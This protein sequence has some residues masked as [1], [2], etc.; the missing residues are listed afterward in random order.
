MRFGPFRSLLFAAACALA[1]CSGSPTSPPPPPVNG[2]PSLNCPASYSLTSPT[3]QPTPVTFDAPSA[4]GGTPPIQVACTPASGV[5]F[6]MGSTTITCTATD[7]KQLTGTCSFTV[8]LVAPPRINVTRF[9]AFGDSM[10]AGE[11]TNPTATGIH[12]L[13]VVP[14]KSYPTDLRNDLTARYT[15][16]TSAILVDNQGLPGELVRDATTRT[17]LA[18]RLA[19]ATYDVVLLMEGAND[20]ASKDTLTIAPTV[21]AMRQ[22]VRDVKARGL[23]VILATLPPQDPTRSLGAGAFV[24]QQYND[25][26]RSM[27]GAENVAVADVFTAFGGDTTT[28]IGSDGLHPTAAGYQR[29]ADTFFSVIRTAFEI[30]STSAPALAA[31]ASRQRPVLT[32]FGRQ[33]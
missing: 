11:I 8:T 22:L 25:A 29:V 5:T 12:K 17:R 18:Q 3:G 14:E 33:R 28:L 30:P 24:V 31:P 4:S 1:G 2:P 26:L 13:V 6:P 16:Q 23:R 32:L 9:L 15:S 19:V 7:A 21:D 27:A 20:I 10:T